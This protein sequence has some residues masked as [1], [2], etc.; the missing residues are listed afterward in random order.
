MLSA[1]GTEVLDAVPVFCTYDSPD[2]IEAAQGIGRSALRAE[3]YVLVGDRSG[4][5]RARVVSGLRGPGVLG[6]GKC[7]QGPDQG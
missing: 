5:R 2:T 1:V 4:P 3:R 6:A 7:R